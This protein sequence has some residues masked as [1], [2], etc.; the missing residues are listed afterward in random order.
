MLLY[1]LMKMHIILLFLELYKKQ[2]SI[3]QAGY[4]DTKHHH[5]RCKQNEFHIRIQYLFRL[6]YFEVRTL[7][8]VIVLEIAWFSSMYIKK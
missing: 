6:V 5:L 4:F 2:L 7:Q 1:E 3:I 8:Y